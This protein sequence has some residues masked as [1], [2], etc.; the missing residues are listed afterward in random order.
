[1]MRRWAVW[2]AAIVILGL[3]NGIVWTLV[4]AW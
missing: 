1:M 4:V 2:I 3:L